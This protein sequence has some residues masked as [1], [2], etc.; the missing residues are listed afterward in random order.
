MLKPDKTINETFESRMAGNQ[1]KARR[2]SIGVLAMLLLLGLVVVGWLALD[3]WLESA[4]ALP[5]AIKGAAWIVAFGV[6]AVATTAG[7]SRR[8]GG[9]CRLKKLYHRVKCRLTSSHETPWHQR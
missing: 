4:K 5:A 1:K 8:S 9:D 7:S 2:F 3:E 6:T